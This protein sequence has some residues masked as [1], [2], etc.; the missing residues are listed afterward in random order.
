MDLEKLIKEHAE[1]LECRAQ[2]NPILCQKLKQLSTAAKPRKKLS[3]SLAPLALLYT[4]LVFAF[5]FVNFQLIDLLKKESPQ[6]A[7]PLVRTAEIF[8]P[9]FPGSISQVIEEVLTWDE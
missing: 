5:T 1:L 6:P 8:Q 3:L 7:P 9:T 4:T 2:K